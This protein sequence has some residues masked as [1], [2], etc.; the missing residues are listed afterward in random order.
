MNTKAPKSVTADQAVA[1]LLNVDYIP[2]GFSLL[3]MTSAF[4]EE[5]QVD[6]E[7]AALDRVAGN[8]KSLLALRASICEARRQLAQQLLES[9]QLELESEDCSVVQIGKEETP[10]FDMLSVSD[11]A[12]YK[13]GIGTPTGINFGNEE[14][15]YDWGDITVKIYAG[16]K[17]GVKIKSGNYRKS[18]FQ[19]I[20]L[21]GKLKNDPNELGGILIG[22]ATGRKFPPTRHLLPSHKTAISKLRNS[23]V[24]LVNLPSDPFL[25]INEGDGWQPRFK[26]IDDRRNADERAKGEAI[27]VPFE[28]TQ[29]A[30]E[31]R[32][33][34]D[35]EHDE[36]Q[37]FISEQ[38]HKKFTGN[39]PN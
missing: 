8:A 1:R 17:L 12:F 2:D 39:P 27:H 38:E 32:Q 36:A 14:I 25:P 11:W 23:L 35:F 3:E 10:H 37:A 30:E 4:L 6:Y 20:G 18:S 5:A 21:M 29:N 26:L 15:T 19:A 13:F 16:Y 28:E 7:N 9:L 24:K 31:K 34:F 33:D 22:L